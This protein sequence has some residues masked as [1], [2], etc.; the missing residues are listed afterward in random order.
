VEVRFASS[1]DGNV[2]G[3]KE[4]MNSRGSGLLAQANPRKGSDE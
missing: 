2:V 3:I 1:E 4:G